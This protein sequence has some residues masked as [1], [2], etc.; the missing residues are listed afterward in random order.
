LVPCPRAKEFQVGFSLCQCAL[1]FLDSQSSE[2]DYF[3]Y[4]IN[5]EATEN[6]YEN[7]FQKIENDAA[8]IYSTIHSGK[9]LTGSQEIT[10]SMF[11]ATLFLR[12]RK[13]REQISP[14]LTRQVESE[15]FFGEAQIRDMQHDF[16]KQGILV[17]AADM[18]AKV[19]QIKRE[20]M[21]PAFS[22]P[23]GI[24]E[25]ARML[26]KNIIGKGRWFVFEAAPGSSFITSDC[27]VQTLNLNGAGHPI[28]LGSGFGHPNTAVVL[29][30]SPLFLAGP[31]GMSWKSSLLGTKDVMVFNEAAVKFAH[32]S[33]YVFEKNNE[34]QTLVDREMNKITFGEN[35]F[36][37][38][39]QG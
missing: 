10:W 25:S 1:R 20:M 3:E 34:I 6:R 23:A 2:E 19:N 9:G 18:R 7:W 12:S 28:T 15:V 24:E 13:V 5:G 21:A 35:A 29:P 33:V 32:R 8:A 27:P 4:T 37:P 39:G 11:L 16:L 17:Y 22:H 30:L 38:R 26:A 14:G 36:V 31:L